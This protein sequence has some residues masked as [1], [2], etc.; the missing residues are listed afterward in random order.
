MAIEVKKRNK[1]TSASLLRRF[2]RKVQQSRMLLEARARQFRL[3]KKSEREKR[4]SALRREKIKKE[5]ERLKK[6]GKFEEYLEKKGK[7]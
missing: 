1:E 3:K 6:L 4:L 5:I 2:V 7:R